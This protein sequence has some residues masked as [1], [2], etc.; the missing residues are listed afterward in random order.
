MSKVIA[1]NAGSSSLKFK[2]F[3][4]PEE[5]SMCSGI[6]ERIGYN[7]SLFTMK[8]DEE[9]LKISQPVLDH[10]EAVRVLLDS[11]ISKNIIKDLHEIKAVGHRVVQGGKYF[12][13]SAPFNEETE[14]LVELLMPLAPLHNGPN[15]VG[16]R[17]FKA[18]LPEVPQVAV[19]DTAFHQSME[20]Q[21]YTF[22]IPH[23]LASKYDIR[24]YGFHGTSHQYVSE[25]GLKY[26]NDKKN[27]RIITCHLGSGSSIAAIKNGKCVATTM[28]LTPLGGIM[29]GTRCG[30]ID[31]S[32]FNFIMKSTGKTSDEVYDLLNKESGFLGVSGVSNDSR[33]VIKAGKEG[34][35]QA[36]LANQL[37]VRRVV[38]FVGQY[39]V[40][41]GGVDL[42]VFTAG[43]G[44]NSSLT[45]Q[46]ICDELKDALN[47][48]IDYD[49]NNSIR[50]IEKLFSTDKSKVKVAL[51]P[52]DEEIMIA[53][54]AFKS[55]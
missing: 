37:F 44:E 48:E 4:M 31:P 42:I 29:M 38:D 50:G 52:T 46:M 13:K 19:F 22:P 18:V 2:L 5:K 53:R 34:N 41:L 12:D 39:F 8:F 26:L 1:I 10:S 25:V 14:K 49:L 45:R 7:D 27:T 15:L 35:V 43:I 51:I 32:V 9:V 55:I 24:R 20:A 33:D 16:F 17:A 40:R 23:D 28:G 47:I 3:E 11:L 54:D 30:D 21:D 36:A 6:I